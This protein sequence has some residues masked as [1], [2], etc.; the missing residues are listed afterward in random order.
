MP[1]KILPDEPKKSSLSSES[2]HRLPAQAASGVAALAPGIFGDVAS[3]VNNYVAGPIAG[4]I[5]GGESIPYEETPIGKLLP[6]TA[7]H[8]K[9]LQE[10]IPYLKP[11]N[12]VE[13]FTNDVVE[14]AGSIF[15]PGVA[16]TKMGL[17]GVSALRSFAAS[18]G[19]NSSGEF[20]KDIT[21]D[22]QKG[23]YAKMG[24]M[25]LFSALNKPG[26]QKEIGSL[27]QRADKLLPANATTNANKLTS[28][29]TRL[30]N[31]VL[32]GR[33]P[34]DLAAS[35]KFVVDEADTVLRQIKDGNI[36]V[37]TLK[38]T[39]RS[40]NEKLQKAIYESPD[41]A[42]RV[43][44]KSLAK[45]INKAINNTLSDYGKTNPKWWKLQKGANEAFGA[46]QQSNF[47]TR[48][49][50][51]NVAGNPLTHGLLHALGVTAGGAG[52]V[53]PYQASKLMYRIYKSPELRK[54]YARIV[55]SAASEN[56]SVM[57]KEIK[58]LDEGLS[59]EDSSKKKF[60]L[61]D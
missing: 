5:T 27:Y 19:A 31:Q 39:L 29:L 56:A 17:R 3:A 41:K 44:A 35:E 6:T 54:H 43:R 24:T 42:T 61:V 25:F 37:N 55:S 12:D 14:D 21:G 23:A 53:I 52:A 26:V 18:L 2:I 1:F 60:R 34:G 4:A 57:N 15:L 8:K 20:V 33:Q 59:K 58:K 16:L 9:N 11:K 30:K 49:I 7:T 40:L 48:F 36:N 50:E 51:H 38:S 22:E 47:I 28:E 46:V 32:S 10:A 13:K 45:G